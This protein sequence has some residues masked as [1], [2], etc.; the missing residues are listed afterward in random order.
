MSTSTRVP[1]AHVVYVGEST[2]PP[3]HEATCAISSLTARMWLADTLPPEARQLRA[4]G[5][6]IA[7]APDA[8]LETRRLARR[9][10]AYLCPVQN[11]GLAEIA[12]DL[13]LYV[14]AEALRSGRL[15]ESPSYRE[16][17]NTL[18]QHDPPP[19]G[20][21]AAQFIDLSRVFLALEHL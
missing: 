3:E 5:C 11:I 15:P 2:P 10:R 17:A 19:R 7:T 14:T 16:I 18:P 12:Q 20:S 6:Q 1:A 9:L 4:E 13:G 8:G 21:P